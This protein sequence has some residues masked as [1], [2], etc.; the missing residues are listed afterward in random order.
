MFYDVTVLDTV[1]DDDGASKGVA[2]YDRALPRDI[3]GAVKKNSRSGVHVQHGPAARLQER[4]EDE[5]GE[6]SVDGSS[7]HC[8]GDSDNLFSDRFASLGSTKTQVNSDEEAI[9]FTVTVD[10]C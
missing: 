5:R 6:K 10:P 8:L 2:L 7:H 9:S 4:G 3:R 1:V